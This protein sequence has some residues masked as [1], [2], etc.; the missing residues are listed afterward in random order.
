M[1]IGGGSAGMVAANQLL[2][3]KIPVLILEKERRTGGKAGA[4]LK[5]RVFEDA[6]HVFP[7]VLRQYARVIDEIG[8]SNNLVGISKFKIW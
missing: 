3:Q 4:D 2:K 8:A 7:H 1:I 6:K 5:D